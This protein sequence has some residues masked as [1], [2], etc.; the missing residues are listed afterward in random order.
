MNYRQQLKNDGYLVVHD[1]ID[2]ET[3]RNTLRLCEQAVVGEKS[4]PSTGL[5][6]RRF[7]SL[8]AIEEVAVPLFERVLDEISRSPWHAS[9]KHCSTL[10][11]EVIKSPTGQGSGGG[12]HI[13][14]KRSQF[15]I[16]VYLTEVSEGDGPLEFLVREDG[17]AFS[18][19]KKD[20]GFFTE[21]TRLHRVQELCSKYKLNRKAV[22]GAAGTVVLADTSCV[23]RGQPL[24]SESVRKV[25]TD[26]RVPW[27]YPAGRSERRLRGESA[28]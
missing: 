10:Y 24:S 13:D 17:S 14:S 20:Y 15:K 3:I 16:F 12:W 28:L 19:A 6:D 26:Y 7:F 22:L 11:N 1:L 18:P 25:L 23:H 4:A 2:D 5:H 21:G 8:S 27:W 9:T